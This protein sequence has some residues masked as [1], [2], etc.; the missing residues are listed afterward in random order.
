MPMT[1]EW[2]TFIAFEHMRKVVE[3]LEM[4]EAEPEVAF[5]YLTSVDRD[6]FIGLTAG[7]KKAAILYSKQFG[8]CQVSTG[9]TMIADSIDNWRSMF[10]KLITELNP[11]A[12][13][14]KSESW[15]SLNREIE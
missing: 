8:F 1:D 15:N 7:R 9:S 3:E 4:I 13:F 11:K 5:P 12:D 6:F 2:K 10:E 14:S